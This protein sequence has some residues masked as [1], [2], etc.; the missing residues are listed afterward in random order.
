MKVVRPKT[1]QLGSSS[2]SEAHRTRGWAFA[3][4]MCS[5]Q[6]Y[7]QE[8][9]TDCQATHV[10]HAFP[11]GHGSNSWRELFIV[12]RRGVLKHHVGVPHGRNKAVN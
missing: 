11:P 3:L 6:H 9:A 8:G 12:S 2:Y 10:Y 5:Y 1:S 7:Q 4:T